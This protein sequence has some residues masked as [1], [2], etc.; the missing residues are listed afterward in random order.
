MGQDTAKRIRAKLRDLASNP[1][2]PNL[3]VSKLQRRDGYR[4]RMAGWRIIFRRI[5][6]QQLIRIVTIETRGQA[7]R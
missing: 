3:D 6:N 2:A 4:L 7:Y 1:Q 5:D